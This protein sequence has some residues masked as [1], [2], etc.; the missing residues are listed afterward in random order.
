[1]TYL[2]VCVGGFIGAMTRY[3]F[4]IYLK[5]VLPLT[6][7]PLSILLINLIGSFGLGLL[8]PNQEWLPSSGQL[9]LVTGFLG[10]FTTFSSFSLDSV[11]LIEKQGYIKA[12]V[13]IFVTTVGCIFSF[14]IGNMVVLSL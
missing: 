7:I 5:K 6:Q 2:A 8:I 3:F 13:Y 10:A 14:F 4:Q 9:F 1:M 11:F 12:F